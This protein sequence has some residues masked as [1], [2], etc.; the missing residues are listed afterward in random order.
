MRL[1]TWSE[2]PPSEKVYLSLAE[3][4]WSEANGDS[5]SSSILMWLLEMNLGFLSA[6]PRCRLRK[7]EHKA[8][9]PFSLFSRPWLRRFAG[10]RHLT[11]TDH[12]QMLFPF[13]MEESE[14]ERAG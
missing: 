13:P 9:C 10:R 6:C 11:L 8:Q 14:L 7:F 2:L 5:P 1:Q 4:H 3:L 12:R